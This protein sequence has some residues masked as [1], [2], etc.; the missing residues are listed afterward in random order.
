M[1]AKVNA[2]QAFWPSRPAPRSTGSGQ[3]E[4]GPPAAKLLGF[5][6]Q[7][8][9]HLWEAGRLGVGETELEQMEFPA[10]SLQDAIRAFT[11]AAYGKPLKF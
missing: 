1:D 6:V 2:M 7:A 8:V 11:T 3:V 9:R 4:A 10:L 5:E